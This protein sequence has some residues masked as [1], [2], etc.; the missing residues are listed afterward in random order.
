MDPVSRRFVWRHID[1]IKKGRVILLTTHAMEEA[2]LL[3][4][5]VA[6]MR[7]GELAAFGSPLQ[8]KTEHGTAL[9]FSLLAGEGRLAE[10]QKY[11]DDY[12]SDSREWV[13]TEFSNAG[14]ILLKI[15]S[16]KEG[17]DSEGI[18]IQK[19]TDFVGWLNDKES[20]IAE[21]GFSNSSLEEVF[22]K[23]TEGD[24][25]SD[26]DTTTGTAFE[27]IIS[28]S[29]NEEVGM[30]GGPNEML[31]MSKANLSSRNQAIVIW[32]FFLQRGWSGRGSIGNYTIFGLFLVGTVLLMLGVGGNAYP[33][34]ALTLV[35]FFMSILL[36]VIVGPVYADRFEGQFYLMK[37][38]GLLPLGYISGL[39]LYA[40]TIQLVYN[41]LTMI[42]VFA[43]PFFRETFACERDATTD[44]DWW[45]GGD[46]Y[47][48]GFGVKEEAYPSQIR[49]FEDEYNGETVTLSA[50]RAPGGFAMALVVALVATIPAVGYS[51][52]T[53][54][55]P[56]Y[57]L[58]LVIIMT[59]TMIASAL[60]VL[61]V[62]LYRSE[63]YYFECS[64]TTNPGF[65]C[66][67]TTFTR[68]SID[69]QFMDCVG[70]D[71]NSDTIRSYCVT[72]AAS[73]LSH[74]GIYQMLSMAYTSKVTFFSEPEGYVQDV[75]IPALDAEVRCKDDTCSFP[76]ANRLF[77]LNLLFTI[78]GGVLFIL[79]G[80]FM[81]FTLGF[82]VGAVQRVRQ[83]F[84]RIFD[85]FRN[86]Q[87]QETM[88][89]E[90][91]EEAELPEVGDEREVVQDKVKPFLI[92]DNLGGLLT[93][94]HASLQREDLDPVLT[95]KLRKVYPA[96]GGRPPMVA[97][98]SLDLHVPKGQVLGLLGKNG[99]GM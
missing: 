10:S 38:Q 97:L 61:P 87:H 45:Y 40:F 69:S 25:A 19:L 55:F 48:W 81:A 16:L 5:E 24:A 82:P 66:S 41:M 89:R 54:F 35:I 91:G 17:S 93:L 39:C 65:V 44:D 84:S 14:T 28:P 22:L 57:R 27:D 51:L 59:C 2:D 18:E 58:P 33:L 30:E 1:E 21:Y 85:C 36:I 83:S 79:L 49:F 32:R 8:L 7:K 73:L 52:T 86:S 60:P 6:I 53:A 88:K 76:F 77:G 92:D 3:A 11:I 42:G 9:Q 26:Q 78:V 37:S 74:F 56:G 13:T 94:N 63:D 29:D 23:V 72:P 70:F 20:P 75:L 71:I 12:F 50:L 98:D 34:P 31:G 43:T 80:L 4:D 15:S 47:S 95:H 68:D 46:C 64:N 96:L 90:S 62:F 99:A 67:N